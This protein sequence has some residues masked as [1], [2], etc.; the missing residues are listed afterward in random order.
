MKISNRETQRWRA[1]ILVLLSTLL[2]F[3]WRVDDSHN[4]DPAELV[5]SVDQGSLAS[6]RN[7]EEV[8]NL[9]VEEESAE[10]AETTEILDGTAAANSADEGEQEEVS[11]FD[12]MY[13]PADAALEQSATASP[14]EKVAAH[15]GA[16]GAVPS[17]AAARAGTR[18]WQSPGTG[19]ASSRRGVPGARSE[20]TKV[21][22]LGSGFE[23]AVQN[24]KERPR[25]K[26]AGEDWAE[27]KTPT[28]KS[29]NAST[30]SQRHLERLWAALDRSQV[31]FQ[32]KGPS[33]AADA[34]RLP[35]VLHSRLFLRYNRTLNRNMVKD[36]LIVKVP[37]GPAFRLHFDPRL[38]AL[39]PNSE[40]TWQFTSCAVVGNSGSLLSGEY[41]M[42]IDSKQAVFRINYAPT[43]G[44]ERYVGSRTT[45]DVVNQQH[46]KVFVPE[47]QA[48][49]HLPEAKRSPMRESI[50]TVF[51]V[52]KPFASKHLY[53]PLL[54]RFNSAN[55]RSRSRVAILSP[56]LVLH[57]H[58]IWRHM[59]KTIEDAAFR[60]TKYHNKPMSGFFA[61]VLASQ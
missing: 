41:G 2:V 33:G 34:R 61:V 59:K 55:S 1:G 30:G 11:A 32:L 27:S 24:T 46:T 51:E 7:A 37:G 5:D 21:E 16:A 22:P 12:S 42:E 52:D 23:G 38:I 36:N 9:E 28:C 19:G 13:S 58:N 47:V 40:P 48:G 45:F 10:A 3:S 39:L 44:F 18:G 49:G 43:H 25:P 6:S 54:R 53:P 29:N 15:A 8:L 20:R 14:P 50:I 4:I 57:S 17:A 26:D 56:D 35:L 60:P 31:N